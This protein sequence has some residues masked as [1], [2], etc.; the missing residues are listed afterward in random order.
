VPRTSIPDIILPGSRN[1]IDKAGDLLRQWWVANLASK[2]TETDEAF[3]DALLLVYRYRGGFQDP[4]SRVTM[5]V[6]S[7]V[8]TEGGPVVVAQRLKRLPTLVDK[9]ARYPKMQV[10]R[11]QDIGGCRAIVR[12]RSH[13]EGVLRRVRKNYDVVRVNNYVEEPKETG[14]RAIH[15]VVRR[16][17]RPIEI[18]LRTPAQQRWGAELDRA[19]GQLG[20]ALKDGTIY[21][22]IVAN[23]AAIA[24]L[25]AQEGDG[26]ITLEVDARFAE[27][28]TTVRELGRKE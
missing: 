24:K 8:K 22:E 18:Q 7:F 17:G 12:S 16:R 26:E 1:Q 3:G 10:T 2:E 20:A 6:R 5:G 11:M 9:L 23:Y 13:A 28:R 27:L 21:P 19:A 4:L 14:Y 25:I 15:V